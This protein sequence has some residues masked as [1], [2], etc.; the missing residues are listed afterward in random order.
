MSDSMNDRLCLGGLWCG[1]GSTFSNP[2][3]DF[4]S[5]EFPQSSDLVG[6]H[7]TIGDP[8]VDSVFGDS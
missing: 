6:G 7:S 8:A 1:G 4:G 3:V 2:L 5:L